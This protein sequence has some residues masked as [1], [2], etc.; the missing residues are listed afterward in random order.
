MSPFKKFSTAPH[1]ARGHWEL[2]GRHRIRW[3]PPR[4]GGPAT[5]PATSIIHSL[6]LKMTIEINDLPIKNGDFP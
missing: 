1:P 2:P 6:L 5:P 3:P 4:L